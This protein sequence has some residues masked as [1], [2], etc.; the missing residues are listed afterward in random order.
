VC[1]KGGGSDG[2]VVGTLVAGSLGAVVAAAWRG[3]QGKV[4]IR[5]LN[6]DGRWRRGRKRGRGRVRKKGVKE[7]GMVVEKRKPDKEGASGPA[8]FGPQAQS[9][10]ARSRCKGLISG[11]TCDPALQE[12]CLAS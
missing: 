6:V 8:G 11:S 12:F 9:G 4:K 5:V 1:R 2:G 3:W 10:E 7:E